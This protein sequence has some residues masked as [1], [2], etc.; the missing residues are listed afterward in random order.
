[1]EYQNYCE[2]AVNTRTR[3][4]DK[5]YT[6][7][8]PNN[9]LGKIKVGSKVIVPFGVGNKLL[10]GFTLRLIS[11][12]NLKKVKDIKC[13]V[14]EDICLT[15]KQIELCKWMRDTY[16][17]T[18]YEAI[19]CLIPTGTT[20]KKKKLYSLKNENFKENSSFENLS[21]RQIEI[22]NLLKEKKE[23]SHNKLIKTLNFD[24]KK[25][26]KHLVSK[27]FISIKEQFYNDVTIKYKK[28]VRLNFNKSDFNNVI[29]NIS[30]KA[31]KQIEIL[32]YLLNV[33]E[34]ELKEL[35]SEL[36]TYRSVV[37]SLV[38]K[39]LVVIEDK[40]DFRSPID[41]RNL[42]KEKPNP[43]NN[44][45]KSVYEN[46]LSTLVREKYKPFLIHGV[47][48]SGKT[49]IYMQLVDHVLKMKKQ[50]II[51]VPEISLTPQ[52]ASKFV[53][54]FKENVA[55]LHSKL[56]LGERFD[57]WKKIKNNEIP[58]VIGA[59]SAVF[60]PCDNLGL[61]IIDE[62]HESSY[63]SEISPKYHT[64][65]I[66]KYRCK[67]DN[68]VLVLGTATPSVESYYKSIK[69][70]YELLELKK[71]FNKNSMPK[72]DIVDMRRELA[73]GNK[74]IFSRKLYDS[75]KEN[76]SNRKQ[77]ILFLNRRGHSTFIS[78]RSCGYVLK[79]PN[80]DISLTYHQKNNLAKCHY[81]GFK[82][83]V[84]KICPD[85]TSKYIK[86]FGSGT[87]KVEEYVKKLF[88][89][90][91]T[92]RLDVDTTSRKG[93]LE[94]I[95]KAFENREAD[96]LIGTQMVTKGLD[97]P[98]VTLVGVLSADIIL[99]L[100][101]YRANERTFQLLTQV[102]GRA[103]RHEF[104]GKVI[105]QTYSPDNFAI[106]SSQNHDYL[107]F[108]NNELSLR[109]E[110]LYPPFYELTNIIIYGEEEK[111]VINSANSLFA[112]LK[113]AVDKEKN[114]AILLGPNP[115]IF[116]KIKGNYRWQIVI[117][118]QGVDRKNIKGI[119]NY[120]CNINRDKIIESNVNL[121]IDINPYNIF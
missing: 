89:S 22:L 51:L 71:R 94:K 47:T 56:S 59:R 18:Y 50:A 33:G 9:L 60:A 19:N 13:L 5:L 99:N 113:Q 27:N 61:I 69:G 15:E 74:S 76:L 98:Y 73:E 92:Q 100:P 26:I 119:I 25:D 28:V 109:K 107:N 68:A 84:P 65:E 54:R 43:L 44:E 52:I 21:E 110:F 32:K 2:I 3:Y 57:Q 70:E 101:D 55:I 46:I 40:K 4:T 106:T 77:T 38:K 34:I 117:K 35:L 12:T 20:L 17:C 102:A 36:N 30:N 90:A 53:R 80:C 116:N 121:S 103:G 114:N 16:L 95:I 64:V 112:K 14:E 86:Y 72:I 67:E 87:E 6:Y 24:C 42:K 7:H 91:K 49:E 83:S 63:K 48:G 105:I 104:K 81:C 115:A 96:I 108:F 78:C 58:I 118:Y 88:P 66:A 37:N 10:E 29:S 85:C 111:A 62:E 23:F 97:F 1:M 120:I 82:S 31:Y 8:I 93:H 45:Q 79:C 41:V 11:N 39:G 75:I